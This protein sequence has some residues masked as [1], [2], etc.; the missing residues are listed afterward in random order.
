MSAIIK[1][2][3]LHDNEHGSQLF[4]GSYFEVVIKRKFG[5]DEFE[6]FLLKGICNQFPAMTSKDK[7]VSQFARTP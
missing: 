6:R 3:C 4:R 2:A 5:G 1:A 7:R